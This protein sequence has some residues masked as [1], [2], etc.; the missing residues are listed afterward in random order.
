M[1]A[2]SKTRKSRA[3]EKASKAVRALFP[4]PPSTFPVNKWKRT[5]LVSGKTLVRTSSWHKAILLTEG[6]SGVQLRFYAW[7]KKHAGGWKAQQWF[8]LSPGTVDRVL[9]ILDEFV[10]AMGP[11]RK[12][13]SRKSK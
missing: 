12:R 6:G 7:V 9:E 11:V 3:N 2:T 8:F 10:E 1:R 5:K 13:R 4:E